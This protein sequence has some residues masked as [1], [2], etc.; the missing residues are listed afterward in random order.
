MIAFIWNCGSSKTNLW[1][2]WVHRAQVKRHTSTVKGHQKK[3]FEWWKWS[4]SWSSWFVVTR[5]TILLKEIYLCINYIVQKVT[6]PQSNF[7]LIAPIPLLSVW[8]LPSLSPCHSCQY[9]PQRWESPQN[10]CVLINHLFAQCIQCPNHV[11]SILCVLGAS[12]ACPQ[13]PAPSL[14]PYPSNWLIA[15]F[16]F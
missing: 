10:I 9:P 12:R 13:F 4:I 3:C 7:I 1:G 5:W 11:H 2:Q 6:E 8:V 15:H 14:H 16:F